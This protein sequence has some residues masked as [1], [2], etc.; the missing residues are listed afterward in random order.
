MKSNAIQQHFYH[1]RAHTRSLARL[2][3]LARLAL[4]QAQAKA[5]A[6]ARLGVGTLAVFFSLA[7]C[8]LGRVGGVAHD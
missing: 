3:R 4:A 6:K 5:K 8:W 2:A 7:F 1:T